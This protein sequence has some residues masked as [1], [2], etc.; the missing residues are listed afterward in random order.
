MR[1]G[2]PLVL[3]TTSLVV[4]AFVVAPW[5]LNIPMGPMLMG[6]LMSA[7]QSPITWLVLA[8]LIVASLLSSALLARAGR[9]RGELEDALRG[10]RTQQQMNPE[11]LA[12]ADMAE[13]EAAMMRAPHAAKVWS[14]F[15]PG[16]ISYRDTLHHCG[17]HDAFDEDRY[18][19]SITLRVGGATLRLPFVNTLPGLMT[20]LRLLE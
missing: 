16:V 6:S 2:F 4:L 13:V 9:R 17:G 7:L 19:E 5:A 15:S 14:S 10:L 3:F 1:R 18:L 11:G 12:E 8:L 20:G